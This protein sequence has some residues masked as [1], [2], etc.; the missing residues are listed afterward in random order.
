M[1]GNSLT[2]LAVSVVHTTAMIA[3]GGAI[4]FAVNEWLGLQ[5]ISK[6]WFN[7]DVVWAASLIIVGLVGI[8]ALNLPG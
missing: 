4:A 5:F 1:A 8:F 3:S 7:L 6:S 2:A